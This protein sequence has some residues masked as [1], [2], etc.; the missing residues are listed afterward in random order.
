MMT[1]VLKEIYDKGVRCELGT[2]EVEDGK[3]AVWSA[4]GLN[5]KF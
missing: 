4:K 5:W 1:R 2:F 3:G